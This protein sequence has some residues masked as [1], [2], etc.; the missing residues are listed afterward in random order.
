MN[1]ESSQ[2]N[3]LEVLRGGFRVSNDTMFRDCVE[4]GSVEPSY[5]TS[6]QVYYGS[7]TPLMLQRRDIGQMEVSE[8]PI[9]TRDGC[10]SP[11]AQNQTTRFI[12]TIIR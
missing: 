10:N 1:M 8:T 2:N 6:S 12:S 3:A 9:L 11:L 7:R 5:T 4:T